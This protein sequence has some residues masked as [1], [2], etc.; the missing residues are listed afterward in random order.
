MSHP[1]LDL[2]PDLILDAVESA[3]VRPDGRLL[4]LNSY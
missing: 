3:G 2:T 1:Y 4:A